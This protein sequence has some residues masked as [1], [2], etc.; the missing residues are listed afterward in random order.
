MADLHP[1]RIHFQDPEL[2]PIDID[3]TDAK[4][5]RGIAEERRRVSPG[6]IRKVKLIREKADD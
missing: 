3:A 1:F 6:A 5:A 4:A 2:A